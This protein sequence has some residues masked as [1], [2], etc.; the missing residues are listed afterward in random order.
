MNHARILVLAAVLATSCALEAA[1]HSWYPKECCSNRD[2]APADHMTTDARGDRIVV[3]GARRVWI[4]DGLTA[5]SSP[6]GRVHI[7]FR[8]VAGE[9]DNSTFM[10]PICLFVPAQS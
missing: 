9:L 5:G 2:C 1:A 6:D 7:C 10:V 4:P 8:V 3:V